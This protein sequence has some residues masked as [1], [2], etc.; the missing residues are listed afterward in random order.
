MGQLLA[1][2]FTATILAYFGAEVIKVEP[3]EGDPIRRWRIMRGDTSLWYYSLGRNKKSVT[4]DLKTPRGRELAAQL[5]ATA[6]VVVENF[7]PGL[8]ESWGLG[9]ADLKASNPDLVYAR[10]SGYG[11][12]GPYAEKPGYA[13]VTE[14]FGGFRYINGEPGKP[15]VRPN[16]SMGDTLA[17]IHAALGIALALIQ[18]SKPGGQGQVVDVAL[19]ES[20]FNLLEG[21]VPEYDGAGAVREPAGTTVTGIVPTNTYPCRD[22]KHVVVGGNGDSI[23]KR[24]MVAVGRPEMARDPALASNAGRVAEQASIEAVLQQWCLARDAAEVIT[25]LEEARV[26]VGPIFSAADM[27]ADPHYQARGLFES[28]EIDGQPL[29]IPAIVPRLDTTPGRTDWPGT[30]IGSHNDEILREVLGLDDAALEELAQAGVIK[31]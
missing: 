8:M 16:I 24:L 5:L 12:S 19:F 30:A 26:P 7:R 15:P 29:Q 21:V 25:V 22:G 4:L 27:L 28:V 18:R 11:Q 23:F 6:D 31:R 17:A 20:V 3:P 10:I 2:P 9:P 1:G 13:S 14:G